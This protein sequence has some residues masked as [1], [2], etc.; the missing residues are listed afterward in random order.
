MQQKFT[1]NAW[2]QKWVLVGDRI[3][4]MV[5]GIVK[6]DLFQPKDPLKPPSQN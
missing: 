4:Q 3:V 5:Q 2:V 6:P 1:A